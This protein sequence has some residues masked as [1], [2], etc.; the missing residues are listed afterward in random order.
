MFMLT[1]NEYRQIDIITTQ[2][3]SA[4]SNQHGFV[5]VN[6]FVSFWNNIIAVPIVNKQYYD[7]A[8]VYLT[9]YIRSENLR[10]ILSFVLRAYSH[11]VGKRN[12]DNLNLMGLIGSQL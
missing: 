3:K 4:D 7:F 12:V 2:I 10:F 6:I 1:K 11:V 8:L 5:R 9:F